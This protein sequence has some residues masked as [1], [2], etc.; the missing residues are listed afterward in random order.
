ML[1]IIQHNP[2][3]L[4]GVFSSATR[5]EIVAN[6]ARIKA[7]IRVNRQISFP[8]D[9]DGVL[10]SPNRTAETIADAESKLALPKDLIL[11]AQFW[12]IDNSEID[13]IAINNLSVGSYD[14]AISIWEKKETL[15]S[16]HNRI[17]S[18][19]L[20]GNYGKAL[21]LA[22]LFY[23]KYSIEFAQLI[24]GKE[25]NIVTSSNPQPPS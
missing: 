20:K 14:K 21:E 9:L 23:G 10:L 19:L 5:K 2:F 6:L 16:V 3:R 12:F 17:I 13:K 22:F 25:S 1:D 18:F 4:I 24:L 11:Y 7:N 8:A 15:S